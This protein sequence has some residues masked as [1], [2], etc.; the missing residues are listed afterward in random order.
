MCEH[1]QGAPYQ[2]YYDDDDYDGSSIAW[3]VFFLHFTLNIFYFFIIN[4]KHVRTSE[5]N[6]HRCIL[7]TL[8]MW[9]YTSLVLRRDTRLLIVPV[10]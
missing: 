9:I 8:M 10:C 1:L 2:V 5:V 4:L 6:V 3:L 7:Q